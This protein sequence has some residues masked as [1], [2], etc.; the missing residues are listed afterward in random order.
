MRSG[1]WFT[2][3]AMLVTAA[4]A[5][6]AADVATWSVSEP[7]GVGWQHEWL[8]AKVELNAGPDG[9]RVGD[10]QVLACHEPRKKNAPAPEPVA[11]PAQFYGPGDALLPPDRVLQGKALVRVLYRA[12]LA[13]GETVRF[14]LADGAP[15][16]PAWPAIDVR[17]TGRRLEVAT[18]GWRF[19]LRT[20]APLPLGTLYGPGE[21]QQLGTSA[22]PEGARPTGVRHTWEERGP[23]R[24]T[25]VRTFAFAEPDRRY[26]VRMTFFAG[27]PWIDL[28]DTYALGRGTALR[29]DLAP[30]EADHVYHPHSYSPRTF[31]PG[32]EAE[33][34]TLQPPQHPIAT[35]GPIWRDIW[36]G[37]GPFAFVYRAPD[38]TV[39]EGADKRTAKR[40]RAEAEADLALTGVGVAAV[41]GSQWTSPE[42]ISLESQNPEIHGHKTEPGRVFVRVPT[43]GGTR[44]WALVIGPPAVRKTMGNLVRRHA[45]TP[46]QK[47][48]TE[49]VL[50]W[51][52]AAPAHTDTFFTQWLDYFNKHMLNP[53]TFPRRIKVP[54][55]PVKSRDLAVLAYQFT[56]PDYWP[57]PQYRWQIGNPNFHTDMYRI[58][59]QIGLAMPD[60]PH[61][62]RWIDYGAANTRANMYG[63]SYASGAWAESLSYSGAFFHVVRF[64]RQIRD[65]GRTD[66]FK[67]WPRI[68]K[69]ATYLACMHTP[70]D[71]RYGSRQKAP[72]G[73]TSPGNYVDRL[74][75][76][77]D[78]YR[79]LDPAFAKALARFPDGGP[80]ALDISSRE[81]FGFGAMLRG[82][83]YDRRH[84]SF[85][86]VKAGPARNHFQGDEL[87]F[88]FAALG[89]PLALDYACHYSPRPW[90]AAMHNRPDMD[91]ERPAAVACRRAF[92]ASDVADVF[93]A[94][95]RTR[96][97]NAVPLEPHETHRPGW[98]YPW[99]TLPEGEA[100]TM[101][102]YVMLVKHDPAESKLA[103]YLVV[104]DEIRS[105]EPVWWNLH[106][107]AR[108]IEVDGQTVRFPGQLDVDATLHVLAPDL[109]EVQKREWGW[110]G[111]STAR[112]STKGEA[113]EKA[114]F[115]K[116]IPKDFEPGTWKDGERGK[117]L[118]L[119]GEAGL[120][121]WLVLLIPHRKGTSA[122]TVERLS[123]T[124]ARVTLG[125]ETETVHLGSDGASQ[126][127]V[128]RG[129][130]RTVLLPAG[131]VKPWNEVEFEPV[132]PAIDQGAL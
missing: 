40:L 44:H 25:L 84:E 38:V 52:S 72:L 5:A 21:G 50:D 16:A 85:C 98:E 37:G 99:R 74:Q 65:S 58:P 24:A 34:T 101:R 17:E 23:A 125:G 124:S 13:S 103:D 28:V 82:N 33:D 73:D 32:G 115:G 131:E 104:R 6:P 92:A 14:S 42:G 47:V 51:D 35:L 68:K 71:P 120:T 110:D 78:D 64:C 30:L 95:E 9:V 26:E 117:W 88:Y 18:A 130:K 66:P 55:G 121:R 97:L 114:F 70:H 27:D 12:G 87:S 126:A 4:T 77:A 102:R 60:H 1:A 75:A 2:G 31:G 76:M 61:A 45:D 123:P 81:F 20:E 53:T 132:D 41:R 100:W 118:R 129:G 29:I 122:P 93:V 112:R 79:D 59:L 7:L 22:W 128:E 96:R 19:V 90:H 80:D 67:E 127:A 108:G 36:F 57:G 46:L 62:G 105:P 94:D 63:D 111:D 15:V 116:V 89:V 39:P 106:M 49:W 83:A 119:R 3:L 43:D 107:L 109:G 8:E 11:V 10:L 113:Y 54:R 56:N 69:V 91:D 86:T 48:L